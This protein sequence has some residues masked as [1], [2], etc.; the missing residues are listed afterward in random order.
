MSRYFIIARGIDVGQRTV[1][2]DNQSI[3]AIIEKGRSTSSLT[4]HMQIR[5]FF[6]KDRVESGEVIIRH[7][8]TEN[9][10]VVIL[11]KP[12]KKDYTESCEQVY[13][14]L[15]SK[16]FTLVFKPYLQ[17]ELCIFSSS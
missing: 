13:V 4:G 3:L 2:Q 9:I 15:V 8:P 12:M 7:L 1:F 6:D 17:V 14:M 11:T 10:V 16:A 5:K